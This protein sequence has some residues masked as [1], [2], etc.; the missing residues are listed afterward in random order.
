MFIKAKEWN[1]AEGY[2]SENENNLF[3]K[4]DAIQVL[5]QYSTILVNQIKS[6]ENALKTTKEQILFAYSMYDTVANSANLV[7]L[8]NQTQDTFNKIMNMQLRIIVPFE[9]IEL[10][11]KFQEISNQPFN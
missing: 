3:H 10:E 5:G 4:L 7:N 2:I 11:T 9:N 1:K 8:I 6:L